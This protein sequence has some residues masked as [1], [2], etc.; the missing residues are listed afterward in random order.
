MSSFPRGFDIF[1][2]RATLAHSQS[3]IIT[4]DAT[5]R[6]VVWL[7]LPVKGSRER[8]FLLTLSPEKV[9]GRGAY[10]AP[11]RRRVTTKEVA[12]NFVAFLL[13]LMLFSPIICFAQNTGFPQGSPGE[14][15]GRQVAAE[16]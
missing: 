14:Q 8:I 3:P 5:I 9:E 13:S 15:A 2:P 7:L 12:M 4:D 10:G 6:I 16:K 11:G 1:C